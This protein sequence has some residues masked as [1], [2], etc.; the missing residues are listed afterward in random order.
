M[1]QVVTFADLE[2]APAGDGVG[3]AAIT[4]GETK[5]MAAEFIRIAPGKSWQATAPKGSD[6]Y[7]FSVAGAGAISGGGRSQKLP[8]QTFATIEEGMA[9]AVDNTDAKPLDIVK[10]IAPLQANGSRHP[11]FKGGV[12][13]AER[14]KTEIVPVPEERKK[15]IYFVG[16]HG[17][18]SERGH[19][20]IVVYDGQTN[21]ALHHHPNAD[22][23]FVLLDGAVEFT[24]DGKAVVV[25]PGQAAYFPTGNQHAL[26][27]ADGHAGASFLEFHIPAGF[28]TVKS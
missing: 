25:K 11:G 12:Q 26:H 15:R 1:G 21:T 18:Q 19:G 8:T 7:L 2:L 27:T 13:V 20:M 17:A 10:V 5:E 22:S 24:V 14:A 4:R 3:A 6:C 9:F 23:M 28:S 16:G